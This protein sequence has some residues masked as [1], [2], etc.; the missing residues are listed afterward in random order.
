[1]NINVTT[2]ETPLSVIKRLVVAYPT[3][4]DG[5]I[6]VMQGKEFLITI[7]DSTKLF[8]VHT[9]CTF[10]LAYREKLQAELNLLE[11][12]NIITPVTEAT[13]WCVPI[14]MTPKKNSDKI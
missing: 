1:M 14:V 9:P 5:H 12:Q 7:E 3:A 8:C 10:P 11:S 13:T 2:I 4:F 6:R